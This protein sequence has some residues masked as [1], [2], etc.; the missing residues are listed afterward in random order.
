MFRHPKV[1]PDGNS[2]LLPISYPAWDV[3]LLCILLIVVLFKFS[4]FL[5]NHKLDIKCFDG[6]ND[7][8]WSTLFIILSGVFTQQGK[9]K[10]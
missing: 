9:K 1:A 3:T 7:S 8:T 10:V 6:L 2:F 4:I 5:E